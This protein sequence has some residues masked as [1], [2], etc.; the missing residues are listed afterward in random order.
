MVQSLVQELLG[1]GL[2]GLP[3]SEKASTAMRKDLPL[4]A[5]RYLRVPSVFGFYG[6]YKT[7]ARDLRLIQGDSLE[8]ASEEL[9][10]VYER[11]QDLAGLHT[12]RN[13]AGRNF[14]DQMS[15]AIEDGLKKGC[16]DRRWYW[17]FN[18]TLASKLHPAEPGTKEADFLYDLIRNDKQQMRKELLDGLCAYTK[19]FDWKAG[20][21]E[22]HFHSYLMK[23][24]RTE[25][26]QLLEAIRAYEQ[27]S[28]ILI[29]AFE[30]MLFYLSN[31]AL[32]CS[33]KELKDLPEIRV[34]ASQLPSLFRECSDLLK[35]VG[36]E[37][38]FHSTSSRFSEPA[39]SDEFVLQLLEHHWFI[40]KRK[41]PL[42]KAAW[43]ERMT[44]DKLILRPTYARRESLVKPN[45]N[46]YVYLYRSNS[47]VS[48]L[49][50]L[51]R[52]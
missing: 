50:D 49:V 26:R 25:I 47:L 19:E 1:N 45:L 2:V 48:F 51:K 9:L 41:P 3:G 18:Q 43:V 5:A 6:V 30:A 14:R 16:V 36:E 33:V 34:A 17:Y 40:Q 38:A 15:K 37:G 35:L 7:L 42:G 39:V 29:N 28:R 10:Q 32:R 31:R 8:E 23:R 20:I 12:N 13:G 4:N 27:F 46:A 21:E 11:E 52:I 44:S 24:V 22:S